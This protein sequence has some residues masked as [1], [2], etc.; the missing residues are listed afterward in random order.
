M[1]NAA[2]ARLAKR[3]ARKLRNLKLARAFSTWRARGL[4]FKHQAQISKFALRKMAKALV[5]ACFVHWACA[6][7]RARR[8]Q[9]AE[10]AGALENRV[11]HC[12]REAADGRAEAAEWRARCLEANAGFDAVKVALAQSQTAEGLRVSPVEV[13]T[14]GLACGGPSPSARGAHAAC[15]FLTRMVPVVGRNLPGSV[16][17]V[18][19]GG[20]DLTERTND[21]HVLSVAEDERDPGKSTCVWTPMACISDTTL[22][23][24]S[25]HG[26]CR[27]SDTEFLVVGGFNGKK[28]LGDVHL[29]TAS[30]NRNEQD[31]VFLGYEHVQLEAA[32]GGGAYKRSHFSL[33]ECA[34]GIFACVA[35]GGYGNGPGGLFNDLW[36]LNTQS[37]KWEEILTHGD[38]PTARRNHAAVPVGGV[39]YLFGGADRSGNRNDLYRLDLQTWGWKRLACSGAVPGP[40]RQ[41][42]MCAQGPRHLLCHGGFDDG[43]LDDLY[44]L[45]L[46]TLAWTQLRVAA[47]VACCL[48]SVFS[49]GSK[50]CTFGGI[51][52]GGALDAVHVL[53]GLGPVSGEDLKAA[54]LEATAAAADCKRLRHG[55]LETIQTLKGE[56]KVARARGAFVEGKCEEFAAKLAEGSRN[57]KVLKAKLQDERDY[58]KRVK[59]EKQQSDAALK[60]SRKEAARELAAA[61]DALDRAEAA[62]RDLQEHI[63]REPERQHALRLGHKKEL[64]D[65]RLALQDA[66][67]A[68][69][70]LEAAAA[71]HDA[72]T[73]G[74]RRAS[75][76][77]AAEVERVGAKLREEA[78]AADGLHRT[79]AQLKQQAQA[80]DLG[81]QEEVQKLRYEMEYEAQV[82]KELEMKVELAETAR[83]QAEDAAQ[84]AMVLAAVKEERRF[85]IED[86]AEEVD[87]EK[88]VTEEIAKRVAAEKEVF[89]LKE[90]LANLGLVL[91]DAEGKA[92]LEK[93]KA[94]EALKVRDEALAYAKGVQGQLLAQYD[95]QR[96]EALQEG[97]ASHALEEE[98]GDEGAA[99]AE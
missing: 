75:D 61:E 58:V 24:R 20:F 97:L 26:I 83:L 17:V 76:E 82:R 71:G 3:F 28:E 27:V 84:E 14:A 31:T 48:H 9:A 16:S 12:Q 81:R 49:V 33:S 74:L 73:A 21:F 80:A 29:I 98:E 95:V 15:G 36:G 72:E 2:R 86:I 69:Q 94:A 68:R 65:L 54:A 44:C 59:A 53:Y 62:R 99:G 55:D 70:A 22:G 19:S 79:I 35:F 60:R 43:F 87:P 5:Q 63:E 66:Q 51:G 30:V 47:P 57:Q 92:K 38:V 7:Q 11:A 64:Q 85:K 56:L 96:A 78:R 40:R 23:P 13:R 45:D 34:H 32:A 37:K 88:F 89:Q 10:R 25:D 46:E 93:A 8:A 18:V 4:E 90:Q 6:T 1:H 52:E 42:A 50:V 39:L 91:T 67:V 41:H 77:L